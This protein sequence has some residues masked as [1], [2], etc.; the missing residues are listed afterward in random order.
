MWL[1]VEGY[2]A[3]GQMSFRSGAYDIISGELEGY[4]AGPG[5]KVYE[6]EHGL[7]EDW[8]DQLGLAAGPSFYFALNNQIVSDNRIPPQGYEFAAYNA[9]GAAPYTAGEPD[10]SRYAGGQFWDTTVYTLPAGVVRGVVRLL[11]QTASKEY[12]EFL[13]D[14]NPNEGDNNGDLLYDLWQSSGRSRPELIAERGFSGE[15]AR[16]FLPSVSRP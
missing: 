12:I 15:T 3:S 6:S 7:T 2:D 1:Q 4:H 13:R 16:A 11:Y 10:P 9:A 14:Q 8:A 5:L